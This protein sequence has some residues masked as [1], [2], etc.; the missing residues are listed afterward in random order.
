MFCVRWLKIYNSQYGCEEDSEGEVA[1][2]L[3]VGQSEC[4][5]SEGLGT[6]VSKRFRDTVLG[7]PEASNKYGDLTPVY[8]IPG[9]NTTMK[10]LKEAL[11]VRK[12]ANAPSPMATTWIDLQLYRDGYDH[13]TIGIKDYTD[14]DDFQFLYWVEVCAHKRY[15]PKYQ[16]K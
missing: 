5:Q 6:R 14:H 11:W 10:D 12:R 4:F 13:D 7:D 16:H 3:Y 15:P 8:P 9:K 1:D 2:L